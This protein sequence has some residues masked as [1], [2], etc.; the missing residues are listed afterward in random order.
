MREIVRRFLLL[1]VVLVLAVV[2]F[3]VLVS[4]LDESPESS[5]VAPENRVD[6]VV[7]VPP[8]AYVVERIGGLLVNVTTMLPPGRDPHTYLPKPREL[9]RIA[10]AD[11][12]FTVDVPLAMRVLDKLETTDGPLRVDHAEGVERRSA[13]GEHDHAGHDHA[14]DHGDSDPHVWM[15]PGNL[16]IM[17]RNTA[18][19]LSQIDPDNAAVYKTNLAQLEQDLVGLDQQIERIL[20]PYKGKAF[21]VYHPA[22]GYFGDAYGLKQKAVEVGGDEPSAAEL[23]QLMVQAR[24]DGVKAIF[25]QEQFSRKGADI[26]AEKIGARVVPLDP[27]DINVPDNLLTIARAIAS[28]YR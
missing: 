1:G 21:Y 16:A 2:G 17:A 7:V 25:V 3:V 19:V 11:V 23:R 26:V 10:G 20:K 22:F 14:H 9:E 15:S 24:I 4:V 18:R 5:R 8:Q 13:D 27:L 12:V 6:V 28:G